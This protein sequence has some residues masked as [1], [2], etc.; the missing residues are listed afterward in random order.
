MAKRD[1]EACVMGLSMHKQPIDASSLDSK[2]PI[3]VT[4][5]L[6]TPEAM[7]AQVENKEEQGIHCAGGAYRI[8]VYH[9]RARAI[10]YAVLVQHLG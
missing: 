3:N 6:Q 9:E 5:R 4:E 8:L 7:L 2:K 1:A 10:P